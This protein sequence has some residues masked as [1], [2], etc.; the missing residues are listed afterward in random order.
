MIPGPSGAGKSTAV[1]LGG[2]EQVLSDE[3][4]AVTPASSELMP[5]IDSSLN[6]KSSPFLMWAT[7]FWSKWDTHIYPLYQGYIPLDLIAF[8]QHGT[9]SSTPQLLPLTRL[10]T[11]TKLI[12]TLVSYEYSKPSQEYLFDWATQISLS[13]PSVVLSFPKKEMWRHHL[14]TT[15]F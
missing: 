7:P 11:V 12:Q 2:F 1:R 13:V 6:D 3:F 8:P 14:T 10:Q 5:S 15:P 9:L 4:I